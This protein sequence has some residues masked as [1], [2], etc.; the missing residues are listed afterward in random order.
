MGEV[1]QLRPESLR[2]EPC[3]VCGEDVERRDGQSWDGDGGLHNYTCRP[4][5][6]VSLDISLIDVE[7]D[8]LVAKA[9]AAL[10]R[11]DDATASRIVIAA[12]YL[13]D[14]IRVLGDVGT[15]RWTKK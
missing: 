5:T 15:E 12:V 7:V 11:G 4:R 8:S 13:R 9:K 14:A 3:Q 1:I 10:D 6:E 2:V